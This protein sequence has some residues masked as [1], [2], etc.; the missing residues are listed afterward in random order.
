MSRATTISPLKCAR[1]SRKSPIDSDEQGDKHAE[2][3]LT[4]ANKWQEKLMATT[5][6]INLPDH[7]RR[8]PKPRACW[9][10]CHPWQCSPGTSRHAAGCNRR[11]FHLLSPRSCIE[12]QVIN[13]PLLLCA[14]LHVGLQ[15]YLYMLQPW[16]PGLAFPLYYLAH[17]AF[18]GPVL[19]VWGW[20]C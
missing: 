16:W 3:M 18:V 17:Y 10:G 12:S 15:N 2:C 8:S 11:P 19:T 13:T 20:S 6:T 1:D 9:E 5:T 14:V 4:K 7:R